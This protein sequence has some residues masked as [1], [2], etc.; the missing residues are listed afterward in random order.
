MFDTIGAEIQFE[1]LGIAAQLNI[2]SL[3]IGIDVNLLGVTS[4]TIAR[5]TD[6][7]KG[8]SGINGFTIGIN[9]GLEDNMGWTGSETEIPLEMIFKKMYC[10][11]CGAQLLKKKITHV[12]KKGDSNF[13]PHMGGKRTLFMTQIKMSHYIYKCPNCGS[14]ISYDDQ[15]VVAKAQKR[16]NK[17]RITEDEL[18]DSCE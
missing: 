8:L 6:L 15:C 16:L 1:T 17:I 3:S 12:C 4:I 2:E 13:Y 18:S 7:G 5:N 14:T 10:H 11:K 9:T